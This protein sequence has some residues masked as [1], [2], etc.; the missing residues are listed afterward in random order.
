MTHVHLWYATCCTGGLE[1]NW[2]LAVMPA[3]P[4]GSITA[5]MHADTFAILEGSEHPEAAFKVMEYLIGDAAGELT[6]IYGGLPARLS[7]QSAYFDYPRRRSVCG[8][9]DQLGCCDRFN[10][11]SGQ[12]E[13]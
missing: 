2:D 1:S 4:D 6:Q 12:P 11:L 5:K 10:G 13:P 7:L 9:G 8:Q 3:A